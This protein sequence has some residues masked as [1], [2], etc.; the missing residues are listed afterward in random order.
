MFA[1]MIESGII[2]GCPAFGA[3]Y[4]IASH[5]FLADIDKILTS[6]EAS[7][8]MTTRKYH[9]RVRGIARACADDI[10]AALH[11]LAHLRRLKRPFDL[12][13]KLA[14]LTLKVSKCYIVPL[15]GQCTPE[16]IQTFTDWLAANIPEWGAFQIVPFLTYL[17]VVLGP[18]ADLEAWKAPLEKWFRRG[19]G[20]VRARAPTSIT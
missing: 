1:F 13:R 9:G 15:G 18:G 4:A 14:G 6:G 16:L 11:A 19:G 20:I 7:G 8:V 17:G 12:S 5:A 10:G 3:L 2:Q